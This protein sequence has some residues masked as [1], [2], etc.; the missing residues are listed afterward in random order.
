MNGTKRLSASALVAL[1]AVLAF[2][3]VGGP[4]EVDAAPNDVVALVVDGLG[5]GPENPS[6]RWTRIVDADTIASRYGLASITAAAGTSA[7]AD[8]VLSGP[9]GA[10]VRVSRARFA[11]DQSLLSDQ[12]ELS[13]VTRSPT[14]LRAAFIGDS[15]GSSIAGSANHELQILTDGMFTSL[16]ADTLPGRFITKA[17]PTPNGL[18][19]AAALPADLDLVI[20]E[21]GYN[22]SSNMAGDVDAMMAV[23]TARGAKRVIWV[24]MADIR[25]TATGASVFRAAN[26]ALAAARNRWPNLSVADWNTASSGADRAYWTTDGVHLSGSGQAEFALWLRQV[27]GGLG[28]IGR[29]APGSGASAPSRRFAPNERIELD[30]VG[31]IVS[32]AD[33]IARAITADV[34]AVALNI[35]AV[36]PTAPG[37][38]TVWPCDM[39][40]PDASNLNFGVGSVVANSVIASVGASGKVCFFS[41]AQT[42]FLVDISGWFPKAS[43]GSPTFIGA[44]PKRVL[45]TRNAIGGP[46][47]RIPAGGT[48]T[49]PMAG[50]SM[51]R[52]DGSNAVIAEDATA[53]ALNATAVGP[54]AAGYFTI[55]PCGAARPESS[56]VNFT[57]GAVVANGVISSLGAGGAI[58]LYANQ[59]SDVLI[60][61][62]GWFSN[63][64]GGQPSFVG[65]VP[66][67]LVDTR[68]AIGGPTG[69][70]TPAGPKV[71]PVRGQTVIVA[72]QAQQV[73][74][75][76]SAVAINVTMTD[77]RAA[78]YATVWPCGT[79]RP[80]A[81]NV[82]FVNR[83]TVANLVIAPLAADGSICIHTSA[84]SHLIVDI[85]GW[86]TGGA[87]A[88]FTGNVPKRLVDTRNNI[89]PAPF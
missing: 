63:G 26:S 3:G 51:Q 78:G 13:I 15:V 77:T 54:S 87:S 33:G 17:P 43:D 45:D 42:E 58:C 74:A 79:P 81:S 70:I 10:T 75:D 39:P 62:L 88:S 27:A 34:S 14:G 64:D 29:K 9:N 6:T 50:V 60:D 38:V 18:E 89:G 37:F 31:A 72:G 67:R 22:P 76:A 5:N 49:I 59:Q 23:L 21:L 25:T 56:N 66:Q 30:I 86:F 69:V 57:A 84:D 2:A 16:D 28:P 83:G 32:G 82:N 80:D 41:N 40:R 47:V 24:N 53:V 8:V 65:N 71:V 46:K 11:T 36:G 7:S 55:W 20:V 1:L 19:A 12:F 68:N 44:V 48:L 85:A 61:V 52:T 35:T 73:P 4:A